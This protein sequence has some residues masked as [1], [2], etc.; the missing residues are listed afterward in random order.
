VA[1]AKKRVQMVAANMARVS[2]LQLD[3]AFA[4]P[5]CALPLHVF[6]A[7]VSPAQQGQT[8]WRSLLAATAPQP[9]G[10]FE[11][12]EL[13]Q[14]HPRSVLSHAVNSMRRRVASWES[15]PGAKLLLRMR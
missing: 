2:V 9:W 10:V 7:L 13:A 6:L 12:L 4:I 14:T 1:T 3:Y 15:L 8:R 5:G 11:R